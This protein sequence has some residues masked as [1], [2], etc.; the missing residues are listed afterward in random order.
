MP[1]E[2]FGEITRIVH[3]AASLGVRKVKITGGGRVGFISSM[4]Q[5]FCGSCTRLRLSADGKL[6]RCL[7]SGIALDFREIL[8][9]APG[10]HDDSSDP[11]TTAM[12][13]FWGAREDKH[14]ELRAA[15]RCRRCP[16][17]GR[18]FRRA[19]SRRRHS[20]GPART[21]EIRVARSRLRPP[22]PRNRGCREVAA[23]A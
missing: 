20:H 9:S 10:E 16:G 7:F 1:E 14:S 19:R 11:V 23:A 17:L 4:T 22:V 13:R 8:R 6:Y 12:A 5:P 3:A 2:L 18:P 15:R 21:A